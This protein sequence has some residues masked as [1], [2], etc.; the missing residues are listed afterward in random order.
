MD[1]SNVARTLRTARPLG[2]ANPTAPINKGWTQALQTRSDPKCNPRRQAAPTP[3]AQSAGPFRL[4]Q[5][6]SGQSAKYPSG[7][8]GSALRDN[9]STSAALESNLEK[10]VASR[11]PDAAAA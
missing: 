7:P 11:F 4:T 3:I 5:R 1:D 2:R 6:S 9:A 10:P 8:I